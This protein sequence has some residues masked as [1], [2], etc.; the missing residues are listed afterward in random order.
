MSPSTT[1]NHNFK[2]FLFT[3]SEILVYVHEINRKAGWNDQADMCMGEAKHKTQ[4]NGRVGWVQQNPT[5]CSGRLTSGKGH[6]A[7]AQCVRLVIRSN[8]Q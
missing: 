6:P 8:V 4:D 5:S 2:N 1:T 3:T 7:Q